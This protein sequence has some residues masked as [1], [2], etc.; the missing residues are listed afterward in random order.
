MKKLT[1]SPKM[2]PM[3]AIKNV[4]YM[5]MAPEPAKTPM[6]VIAMEPG[7]KPPTTIK[8]SAKA[9]IKVIN[10]ADSG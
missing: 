6:A 7:I 9:M 10:K 1:P 3:M 4:I 8:D 5:S 2:A